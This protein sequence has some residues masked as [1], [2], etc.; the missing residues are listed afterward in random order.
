MKKAYI[1]IDIGTTATKA[2]CFDSS[3]KVLHQFTK[4]YPMYHAEESWSTQKPSEILEAVLFSIKEITKN[5]QPEFISFSSAMQSILLINKEGVPISDA[6]LWADNRALSIA[7]EL[8][9]T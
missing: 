2:V 9:T 7:S 4:E 3:G 6:L 1:G 5:Y 8:K